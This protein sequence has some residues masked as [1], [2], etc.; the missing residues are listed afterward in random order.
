[1]IDNLAF[2]F[3][4]LGLFL[5]LLAAIGLIKFQDM[6]IKLHVTSKSTTVGLGIVLLG[7]AI[8]FNT[9]EIWLKV[10]L[11]KFIIFFT[12]PMISALIASRVIGGDS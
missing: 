9:V 10:L 8:K 1:M 3:M 7:L 4:F 5:I 6:L 11:V 2:L 12:V